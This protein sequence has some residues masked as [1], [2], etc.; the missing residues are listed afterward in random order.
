[1]GYATSIKCNYYTKP[2]TL[3]AQTVCNEV[4]SKKVLGFEFDVNQEL[5]DDCCGFFSVPIVTMLR[6]STLQGIA[7]ATFSKR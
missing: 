4:C 6:L 2:M 3:R 5:E 7:N 1:M